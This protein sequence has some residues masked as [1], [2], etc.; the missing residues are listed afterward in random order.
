[1]KRI[2]RLVALA[3]VV[4]AILAQ[5]PG[6]LRSACQPLH[7]RPIGITTLFTQV[8]RRLILRSSPQMTHSPGLS[9]RQQSVYRHAPYKQS[10]SKKGRG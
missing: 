5:E 4:A 6:S 10:R 3:L 2:S 7:L 8:P 1:M 9:L